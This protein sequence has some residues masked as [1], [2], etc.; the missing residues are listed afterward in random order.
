MV[1]TMDMTAHDRVYLS[2][3]LKHRRESSQNLIGKDSGFAVRKTCFVHELLEYRIIRID[4]SRSIKVDEDIS[5][6]LD[7]WNPFDDSTL[8][9]ER[10][11][12]IS[13]D[14][15]LSSTGLGIPFQRP[16][17]QPVELHKALVSSQIIFGLDEKHVVLPVAASRRESPWLGQR[18]EHQYIVQERIDGNHI[19]GEGFVLLDK[20]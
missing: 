14:I 5:Y 3:A 17:D 11:H 12:S 18:A 15:Q 9:V 10:C 4:L 7:A 19:P 20:F 1:P 13:S 16:I 6:R 2:R 8:L